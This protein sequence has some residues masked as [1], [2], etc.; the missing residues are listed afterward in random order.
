M[1]VQTRKEKRSLLLEQEH[2]ANARLRRI[3]GRG[4]VEAS[5]YPVHED[6]PPWIPLIRRRFWSPD[7]LQEEPAA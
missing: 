5:F 3:A 2:V 7:E 4:M 1:T 6:Q